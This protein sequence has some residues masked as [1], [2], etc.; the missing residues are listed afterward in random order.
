MML[1]SCKKDEHKD[2]LE[3]GAN[4]VLTASSTTPLVLDKSNNDAVT[5]TL[6][7]T[8]PE[9]KFTSG[10][11]SL[12]VIY[13]IQI[14]T[15]GA[16]FGS[17]IKQEKVVSA[18]LGIALTTKD[19]NTLLT[20]MELKDGVSHDIDIRVKASLINNNAPL[21]SNVLKMKITP[22]LDFAVEPPGTQANNYDDGNL[23]VTGNCFPGPDWNNPIPAPYDVTLKFNK[24]DKLHY[25]LIV[26]FDAAGGYKMIQKQGD[27]S[28][29]YHALVANTALSGEFEKKDSDPQFASPGVGKY[30]IEVNFQTGKYKLTPQ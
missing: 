22:Y 7:W 16:N 11:S 25:E 20:K 19:L 24:I 30:K 9:Y 10:V 14:D 12:D 23:W 4:P 28:T 21:Y 13:T 17:S 15:T 5:L 27:W 1:A 6:N 18:D 26:D 3:S 2:Y 8:N 29:Q